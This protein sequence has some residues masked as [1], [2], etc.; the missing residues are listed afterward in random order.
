MS[1]PSKINRKPSFKGAAGVV[2]FHTDDDTPTGSENKATSTAPQ[3][4]DLSDA[5]RHTSGVLPNV[6]K[7]TGYFFVGTFERNLMHRAVHKCIDKG[8][9]L[10]YE[11]HNGC[12]KHGTALRDYEYPRKVNAFA[13]YNKW[14]SKLAQNNNE[15]YDAKGNRTLTVAEGWRWVQVNFVCNYYVVEKEMCLELGDVKCDLLSHYYAECI[16][17]ATKQVLK[18]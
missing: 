14:S 13:E 17:S 1:D 11:Y 16:S 18:L 8:V 3:T 4:E 10:E 5:R 7:D 12:D 6:D 2:H 15:F 9:V